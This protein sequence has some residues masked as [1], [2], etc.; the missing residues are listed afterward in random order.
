MEICSVLEAFEDVFLLNG[1]MEMKYSYNFKSQGK[2]LSLWKGIIPVLQ[3][4]NGSR[5]SD[6]HRKS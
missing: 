2:K 1:W 3:D 4:L 5:V 6:L